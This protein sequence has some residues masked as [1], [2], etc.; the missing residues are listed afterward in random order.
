MMVSV[1]ER[2]LTLLEGHQPAGPVELECVERVRAF[3]MQ[4]EAP[5][6]RG[7]ERGHVVA[8]GL[9]AS[10]DLGRVVLV[11]H[12]GLD[13]WLQP[14]GHAEKGEVRPGRIARR[15]AVEETGLEVEPHSLWEGLL[16]V[17]VH[18]IPAGGGMGEHEHYDLRFLFEADP[19]KEPVAPKGEAFDARWFSLEDARR[20]LGLDG[21]LQRLLWKVH[22]L[23][24]DAGFQAR[25]L[26]ENGDV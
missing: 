4:E 18:T 14:G 5:L 2:V 19:G 11:H 25:T 22:S 7:N 6:D 9:V 26:Q 23:R 24:V 8:S 10:P 1:R 16:D 21:G 12:R 17:D 13:R 15:E 3:V 20:G